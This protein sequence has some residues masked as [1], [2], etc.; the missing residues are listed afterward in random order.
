MNF[1]LIKYKYAQ[2][3]VYFLLDNKMAIKNIIYIIR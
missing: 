3:L 1:I 2:S